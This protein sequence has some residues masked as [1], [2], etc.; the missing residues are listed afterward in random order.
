MNFEP[1]VFGRHGALIS[2]NLQHVTAGSCS[3]LALIVDHDLGFL[4]WLGEVFVEAGCQAVPALQCRQALALAKQLKPPITI[5]VLN[6]ELAGAARA[7]KL[8]VAAN[9]AMQIVFI[10]SATVDPDAGGIN[11][12]SQDSIHSIGIRARFSLERP[13]PWE[14]ISRQRWVAKIRKMLAQ[15]C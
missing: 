15:R 9:P 3:A 12:G 1:L 8:L 4:M 5:L 10:R 14:P 7:V 11:Y 13:S 2:K 6:P